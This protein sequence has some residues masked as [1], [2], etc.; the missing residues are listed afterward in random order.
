MIK[1]SKVKDSIVD[2]IND[3]SLETSVIISSIMNEVCVMKYCPNCGNPV[4]EGVNFCSNCGETL[5]SIDEA[6]LTNNDGSLVSNEEVDSR[7]IETTPEAFDTKGSK[8]DAKESFRNKTKKR[9]ISFWNRLDTFS[10]VILITSGLIAILSIIAFCVRKVGPIIISV[11][12]IGAIVSAVLMHKGKIKLRWNW[13]KY[14]VLGTAI[15][16]SVANITLYSA[17]KQAHS[18]PSETEKPPAAEQEQQETEPVE[19]TV[20]APLSGR[21][22]VGR[23]KAD[24]K[25][26]FSEA[27]FTNIT[28]KELLDL[29]YSDSQKDQAVDSVSIDGNSDYDSNKDFKSNSSVVI[30][31]HTF[32]EVQSPIDSEAAKMMDP[33][34][35]V[36]TL[37]DAGFV[38]IKTSEVIDLDPDTSDSEFQNEVEING[39]SSFTKASTFPVN[40]KIDI[41]THRAY[42]KYTLK[43]IVDFVPN[44]IFSK[45]NVNIDVNGIK[46]TLNHG[47]DAEYEYRL[48]PGKY[49]VS[50]TNVESASVKG[51]ADIDLSGDTEVAYKINCY[52]D[53]ISVEKI[54]EE[55]KSA[56]KENEAMVPLSAHDCKD[57]NYREIEEAFKN[58]GF[59]DIKTDILYDISFGFTAEGSVK[60]VSVNGK[61]EFARGDVFAREVPVIITYHMKKEDDPNKPS[62]ES[63]NAIGET[64]NSTNAETPQE[65]VILTKENNED[66]AALLTANAVDGDAQDAFVQ[67]YKGRTIEFDCIVM[68]LA[69]EP[70]SDTIYSYI[71][72][73]GEDE[74]NIGAA[75]FYVDRIGFVGFHWDK[76]T[77]PEFV[78][79]GSKMRLR[80]K[81]SSGDDPTFIYL[82]PVKTWGR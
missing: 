68:T 71:L 5:K 80:A 48:T 35:L 37:S 18:K 40:A 63:D 12:Q 4:N 28:E 31:Y 29:E 32:K 82:V 75:L 44:L 45:Y 17:G 76:E 24:I 15:L 66:L 36:K 41:V 25:N 67:K 54:Y 50:F 47:E 81:V 57:K 8:D 77:R 65:E 13:I 30:T 46:N 74:E 53:K 49:T 62:L 60:Q 51:T 72:I 42:E 39:F 1:K 19:T 58:A 79:A 26:A 56:V 33:G 59:T 34:E 64:A 6:Q 10:K 78:T 9:I 20:Y 43:V 70:G 2:E 23:P 55:N 16:L 38:E 11:L 27:G 69:Q 52:N 21:E 73:P 61:A 3:Q 22:C 7:P 14:I